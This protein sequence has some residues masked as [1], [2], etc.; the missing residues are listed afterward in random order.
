[1]VRIPV[2]LDTTARVKFPVS[3]TFVYVVANSAKI[4]RVRSFCV[5]LD[6]N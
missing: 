1:M 2:D 4:A 3:L 6:P 5:L